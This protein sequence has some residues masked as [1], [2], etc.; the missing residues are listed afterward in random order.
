[1]VKV[2]SL[3]LHRTRAQHF[4]DSSSSVLEFE[5]REE[6]SM[7]EGESLTPRLSSLSVPVLMKSCARS[8][9]TGHA[10]GVHVVGPR[11]CVDEAE[12]L[13]ESG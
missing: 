5:P 6:R 3:N 8:L 9:D 12:F 10:C 13:S 2:K 7:K 11:P 1:M 4:R